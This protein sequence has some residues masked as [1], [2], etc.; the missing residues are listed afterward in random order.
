M[1]NNTREQDGSDEAARLASQGGRA[2]ATKLTPEERRESARQAAVARWEREP[3]K[4][5]RET[6]SGVLE[7]GNLQ[8]PCGNL[9]NG[10]RVLS[11]RGIGRAFGSRQTGTRHTGTGT[12]Q[13]PP[14]LA[15]KNLLPFIPEALMVRLTS[16]VLYRHRAGGGVIAYGYEATMLPEICAT[17]LDADKAGLLRAAQ[18]RLVSAASALLRGFAK[19][20]IIA[21]VDEATGYQADRAKDELQRILQAYVVEEMRPWL[22]MF[23]NDFFRQ[24]YRLQGWKFQEGCAKRPQYIGKL[25]NEWV[26]G[27]L[28]PPVL[29]ELCRRNP[30]VEGRRRHKHHQFLTEETGIPHLDRQIAA[31]TALLRASRDLS[32]F[33]EMLKRA[34]PKLGDQFGFQFPDHDRP[35]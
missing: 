27:R 13:L 20:G 19:V 8:I 15:A 30:A 4:Y 31:V 1:G 26:Y 12:P 3:S 17:I 35:E 25:I 33:T 11:Y 5:P 29:P 7:I 2:R 22:S 6:H 24:I 18:Q 32:M 34:F 14:F 21:L 10:M 28:P 9:D 23:P 16:P